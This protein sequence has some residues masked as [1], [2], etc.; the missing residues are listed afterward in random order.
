MRFTSQNE[1]RNFIMF[2]FKTKAFTGISP[3]EVL[4]KVED[5]FRN[6][7]KANVPISR[8]D[9]HLDYNEKFIEFKFAVKLNCIELRKLKIENRDK[10]AILTLPFSDIFQEEKL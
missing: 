3:V 7:F 5:F 4:S 9:C 8:W 10:I 2:L 6:N 1:F